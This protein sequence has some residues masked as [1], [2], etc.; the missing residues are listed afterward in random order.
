MTQPN[1]SALESFD[2]PNEKL[3]RRFPP[4]HPTDSRHQYLQ[5]D[6]Q[7]AFTLTPMA[8]ACP[9][10]SVNRQALSEAEDVIKKGIPSNKHHYGIAAITVGD[11]RYE[12]NSSQGMYYVCDIA[13]LPKEENQS[14][15][16]I[17]VFFKST[18]HA[19]AT[20]VSKE[21]SKQIRTALAPRFYISK[22]P[23]SQ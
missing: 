3:Y 8:L 2:D 16:E 23:D 6:H 11:A 20:K 13:Y 9:R 10:C 18:S 22:L 21:V 14:H 7:G 5:P 12:Y 19:C 1:G 17:Q 15:S 4:N